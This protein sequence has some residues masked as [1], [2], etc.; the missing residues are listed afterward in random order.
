ML[1]RKNALWMI[2]PPSIDKSM[3]P[4]FGKHGTKQ[5]IYCKPI[6]FRFKWRVLATPLGYLLYSILPLRWQGFNSAGEW[7]HETRSYCISSCK[8]SQQNSCNKDLQLSHCHGQLFYS[9][10]F[11][12]VNE[13]CCNKN[14]ESKPNGKCS[15]AR[16]GKNQKREA[17]IIRCG[18]WCVTSLQYLGKI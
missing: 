10:S 17:W 9:P 7:K 2:S 5:Y 12:E 14:C 18:Y 1:L 16:Y 8:L 6:N 3:V 11:S 4:Y 15:I 13:R